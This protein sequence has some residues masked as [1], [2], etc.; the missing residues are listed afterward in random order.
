MIAFGFLLKKKEQAAIDTLTAGIERH[1][2]VGFLQTSLSHALADLIDRANTKESHK[3]ELMA[4]AIAAAELATELDP[5]DELAHLA[6]A[7]IQIRAGRN[8]YAEE[9]AKAVLAIDPNSHEA[10]QM[11]GVLAE[12]RDAF[13]EASAHFVEATRLDEGKESMHSLRRL[14]KP[15]WIGGVALQ[16]VSVWLLLFLVVRIAVIAAGMSPFSGWIA[17]L[18]VFGLL[19]GAYTVWNRHRSRAALSAGAREVL[20]AKHSRSTGDR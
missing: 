12:E 2:E 3:P 16:L 19:S 7:R 10:H 11:L 15:N 4:R 9:S 20:S 5:T 17:S 1:P 13:D 6:M 14:R 8:F 18:V